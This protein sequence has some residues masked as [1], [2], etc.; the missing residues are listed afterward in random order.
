[1]YEK[2][3]DHRSILL[4]IYLFIYLFTYALSSLTIINKSHCAKTYNKEI[5]VR[6]IT[7]YVWDILALGPNLKPHVRV[8]AVNGKWE[9]CVT[10]LQSYISL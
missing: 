9:V 4:F 6:N 3:Q 8:E 7:N 1:V 5:N 10:D 2:L